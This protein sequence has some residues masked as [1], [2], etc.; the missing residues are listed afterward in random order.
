MT[1]FTMTPAAPG[2]VPA[3]P[4][5]F[6]KQIQ[7]RYNGTNLGGPDATVVDFVGAGVT[8]TRGTGANAGIVTVTAS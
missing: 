2:N 7:F 3:A 6:P 1:S 4:Q 5:N 8:A